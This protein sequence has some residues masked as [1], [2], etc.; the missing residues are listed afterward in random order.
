MTL[1]R[2]TLLFFCVQA[3]FAFAS[4][5][6]DTLSN[7]DKT[8]FI[9][10]DEADKGSTSYSIPNGSLTNIQQYRNRYNLG[11]VGLAIT[12][13]Y[14]PVFQTGL[15]FNFMQNNFREYIYESPKMRYFNTKTPYTELLFIVGSKKELNSRFVHS[16]NINKNLNFT[17]NFQR[18]RSDG[19]YNRQNT[20]HTDVALSGNY[21]SS[22]KR[23]FL[24]STIIYNSL[25]NAE[26]GGI[27]SDSTFENLP[28]RDRK[29]LD[30][31]LASASR[32]YHS[33]SFYLKQYINIGHKTQ[34]ADTSESAQVSPSSVLSHSVLIR[35]E[36]YTFSDPN[37][38]SGFY[39][40]IY[41]DSLRTYDSTYIF[42]IENKIAWRLL[43]NKRS[44]LKRSIGI[45]LD[46]KHQ[47]V[48]LS[49]YAGKDTVINSA[50]VVPGNKKLNGTTFEN[51]IAGAELFN[52]NTK[53]LETL[54]RCEYVIGGYNAGD[55]SFNGILN[56]KAD[57]L[58]IFGFSG[59]FVNRKPDNIYLNYNSNHYRWKNSFEKI[60][61]A[62]ARLFYKLIKYDLEL[63]ATA[64][65]YLNYV[66]FDAYRSAQEK[67]TIQG[68]SAYLTKSFHLKHFV[69]RNTVTYQYIPDSMVVRLPQWITEHSIYYENNLFKN[70]LRLQVGLDVFY[71][72]AYFANS[73]APALGQF[74][75]QGQ[76]KI[77]NYPYVDV[78]INMKISRLRL[79]LKYENLNSFLGY[80]SYYYAPH[81]PWTDAAFKAGV[82]W[83][84]FD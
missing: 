3:T 58:N 53:K 45:G 12:N 66:Y 39:K 43:E 64:N 23:Y 16:Q 30:I 50:Q 82:I 9:L 79:F 28:V 80:T 76:K 8:K 78:F 41:N 17:F 35:D 13:L 57:S 18:I 19:F 25:K 54:L 74:Y 21:K 70:A 51:V 7:A 44:G 46:V 11:N 71:N 10:E 75:V 77:G 32:K 61:F 33:R 2:T 38:V 24:I 73:W 40:N 56:Y 83:K 26:N 84:F 22:N 62:N 20:N 60:S 1:I 67:N 37:P 4:I 36:F 49:Q 55:N 65:Q 81:Y 5:P 63:G 14:F 42:S 34:G 6:A 27:A 48:K 72:S 52:F 31:N 59:S 47:F 15:G 29:L 68:F 69:F